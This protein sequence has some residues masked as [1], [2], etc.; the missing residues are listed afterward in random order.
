MTV[1]PLADLAYGASPPYRR[2]LDG[3]FVFPVQVKVPFGVARRGTFV[4]RVRFAGA[5]LEGGQL[6]YG[7]HWLCPAGT[8]DAIFLATAG[9]RRLCQACIAART[10]V[11]YRC[12]DRDGQLLYVGVTNCRYERMY[13][14]KKGSPWWPEVHHTRFRYFPTIGEAHAAEV[15]AILTEF[16]AHSDPPH[17]IGVSEPDEVAA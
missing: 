12:F 2:S 10:P 14:H 17:G 1:H 11:V 6:R 7:A 8:S 9:D 13:Q 3:A 16:P 15:E 5:V 4:H